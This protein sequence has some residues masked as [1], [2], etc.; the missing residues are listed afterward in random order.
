MIAPYTATMALPQ[1]DYDKLDDLLRSLL[2]CTRPVTEETVM[3][4]R[5]LQEFVDPNWKPVVKEDVVVEKPVSLPKRRGKKR[6]Q[7]SK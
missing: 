6:K 1:E 7:P 3:R 4:M 5:K 2:T